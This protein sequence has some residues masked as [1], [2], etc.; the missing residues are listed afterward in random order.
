MKHKWNWLL[1]G[2]ILLIFPIVNAKAQIAD[3]KELTFNYAK[4]LKIETL[5][6]KVNVKKST[7][8]KVHLTLQWD[9][10]PQSNFRP[11]INEED[12]VIILKEVFEG[13][14]YKGGSIWMLQVPDGINLDV[15][16]TSGSVELNNV[17]GT[18]KIQTTTGNINATE[19]AFKNESIFTTSMGKIKI[20]LSEKLTKNITVR[21]IT[22]E[23]ILDFNHNDFD[24][25]IVMTARKNRGKI[26]S[27][28]ETK[29]TEI[30][31]KDANHLDSMDDVQREKEFVKQTF[32]SVNN[33]PEIYIETE[34]G[35]AKIIK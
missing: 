30:I 18:F 22:G 29:K 35:L 25:K 26:E 15:F 32:L 4:E 33:T 19:V 10:V 20:K 1:I 34:V 3:K 2:I 14:T 17:Y 9:Y 27:F 7:D 5:S 21:S 31:M 23:A 11:K 28:L 24:G 6:G 16:A 8:S 13:S 12:G